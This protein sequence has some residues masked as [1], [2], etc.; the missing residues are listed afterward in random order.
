[1][2]KIIFKLLARILFARESNIKKHINRK[3]YIFYF[4]IRGNVI[5]RKVIRGNVTRRNLTP[6]NVTRGYLIR[7]I[8]VDYGEILLE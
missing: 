7:R 5:R 4:S 1:M 6:G 3:K 8:E 2:V